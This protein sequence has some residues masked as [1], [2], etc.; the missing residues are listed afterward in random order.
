MEACIPYYYSYRGGLEHTYDYPCLPVDP[1]FHSPRTIPS[2]YA[3]GA[4]LCIVLA[5]VLLLH[6]SP[7]S[8]SVL[9]N[10]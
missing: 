8:G 6:E 7:G 2:V 4:L 3:T 9:A 10:S 1:A 5:T